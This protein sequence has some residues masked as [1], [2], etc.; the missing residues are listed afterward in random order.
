MAAQ[1][2][3]RVP[4][5]NGEVLAVPTLESIPKLIEENQRRLAAANVAID[6]SPLKEF[7]TLARSE[8]MAILGSPPSDGS[9]FLSQPLILTGHQ[10]ELSH[11]GVW[12]KN[13]V[14]HGMA[15]IVGGVPLN[16]IVD[17]D[18]LKS[19]SLLVPGF[20]TGDTSSVHLEHLA[21]DIQTAEMP[22]EERQ[23]IDAD[24]FRSFPE[25]AKSIT[26]EWGYEPLLRHV[27]K[28]ERNVGCAF[29]AARLACEREWGCLNRELTVGRL[30]QTD[31][32]R[33]FAKHIL[34][35]L[36]RFR[37]VYNSAI[38]SYRWA[39]RIKSQSHPAPELSGDEAPFW[40]KT[41]TGGQRIRAKQASDIKS[42]RPRALTLTLFARLCV[43]DFFIHGIGGG[44]YDEVTDLIIRDYFGAEPPAYQVLSA[45]LHL[46]LPSF[47]T[48][49]ES[50][51]RSERLLRDLRWNPQYHLK[52]EETVSAAVLQLIAEKEMLTET[53]PPSTDHPARR[54]WFRALQHLTGR[55]RP[56][57]EG[58]ISAAQETIRRQELE[59]QANRVL[60]R[61]DY[62]WVFFPESTLRPFLQRFLNL[63]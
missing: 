27:W 61:R 41:A 50:V 12:V 10:P 53:E 20:R 11:P 46:P 2:R 14:L 24:L 59:L 63:E 21:F 35:D 51:Q 16:L 3:F 30:S 52:S 28:T 58:R 33:R 8:I 54:Q 48:T 40:E 62:S 25:R 31:C 36:P 6:G 56:F 43:G 47:P 18:T 19:T 42:L 17:N 5:Q 29:V 45:T 23:V 57:V 9:G 38:Q 26:K 7:R 32:F 49:V 4:S 13:F 55:L 60:Q 34:Q 39:N 37:E 44:K 15:K 1:K 22:Y